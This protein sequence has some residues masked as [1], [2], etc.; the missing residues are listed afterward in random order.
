MKSETVVNL[1]FAVVIIAVI[2]FLVVANS[3]HEHGGE[4]GHSHGQAPT[5]HESLDS[6]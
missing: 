4:H 6:Q 3:G 2:A 1:I 5:T